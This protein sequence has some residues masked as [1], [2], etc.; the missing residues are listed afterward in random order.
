MNIFR[1]FESKNFM[2]ICSKTH[3]IAPFKIFFRGTMPR[4]PL[5]NAWLRHALQAPKK[6]ATLAK[7]C[8]RQCTTTEKFI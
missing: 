8:I 7:S 4:T 5:A 2:K 6:L 1:L 3:Q